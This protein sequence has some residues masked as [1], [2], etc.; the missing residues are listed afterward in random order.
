MSNKENY[1]KHS[2]NSKKNETKISDNTVIYK[3]ISEEQL[4][5]KKE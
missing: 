1:G 3:P 2:D 5:K 4:K